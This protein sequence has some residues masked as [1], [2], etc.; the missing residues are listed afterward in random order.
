LFDREEKKDRALKKQSL[1]TRLKILKREFP[2]DFTSPVD[3]NFSLNRLEKYE[4]LLGNLRFSCSSKENRLSNL[5]S[6][7]N[8]MKKA[9]HNSG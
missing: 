6:T 1:K 5:V 7:L 9:K 4:E 3:N 2:E 8:R